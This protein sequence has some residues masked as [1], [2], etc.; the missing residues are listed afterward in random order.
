[1]NMP[2]DHLELI[3]EAQDRLMDELLRTGRAV[4]ETPNLRLRMWLDADHH[5]C[6]ELDA[7]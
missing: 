2:L 6:S 5:V 4:Y 1:M 7:K 3:R